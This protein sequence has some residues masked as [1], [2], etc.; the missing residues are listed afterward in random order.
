MG[1]ESSERTIDSHT[2]SRVCWEW[3]SFIGCNHATSDITS[4]QSQP[5]WQYTSTMLPKIVCRG[6]WPHYCHN[7]L[8]RQ[9]SKLFMKCIKSCR[10]LTV[11]D[12]WFLGSSAHNPHANKFI[13]WNPHIILMCRKWHGFIICVDGR[14]LYTLRVHATRMLVA[15]S[16]CQLPVDIQQDMRLSSDTF[17]WYT[18]RMPVHRLIFTRV[19]PTLRLHES[20]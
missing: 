4:K 8:I 14:L 15:V 6:M 19:D 3:Q 2:F 5:K 18:R 1:R 17:S 16:C 7:K 13:E 11:T 10:I 9:I 20:E 12:A